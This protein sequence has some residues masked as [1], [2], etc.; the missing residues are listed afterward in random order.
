MHRDSIGAVSAKATSSSISNLQYDKEELPE[1]TDIT[2]YTI[3]NQSG[4]IILK[5]NGET[6]GAK[7]D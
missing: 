7:L 1:G 3:G 6:P 2:K 4:E 5:S